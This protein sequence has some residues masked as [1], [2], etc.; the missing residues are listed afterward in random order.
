MRFPTVRAPGL[1]L[2]LLATQPGA[3]LG[4]RRLLQSAAADPPSFLPPRYP[5]K[6]KWYELTLQL[7]NLDKYV[8]FH[9][10]VQNHRDAGFAVLA[11]INLNVGLY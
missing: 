8:R 1:W 4:R 2:T 6:A 9:V 10:N 5:L 11:M 3:C 7:T